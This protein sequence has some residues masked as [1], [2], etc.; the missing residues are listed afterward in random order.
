MPPRRR[1]RARRTRNRRTNKE[2]FLDALGQA[3]GNQQRLVSNAT[4]QEALNWESE[5]YNRIKQELLDEKKIIIGRGYGGS[6]GLAKAPGSGSL[7][8]FVSYCHADEALKNQLLSH[9]M[10]LKRMELIEVWHD[11]KIPAGGEWEQ[12]I[13]ANLEQA[14]IILMLIS[15][16]FINS[17]Y[18]YDI[19]L[20]RAI[21]KHEAGS[22]VVVPII[23]RSCM[24][25]HTSFSKLQALPKDGKP[26]CS[27]SDKDEAFTEIAGKIKEEAERL[28]ASR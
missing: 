2:L 1:R 25:K 14:D 26:V 15:I 19:E 23:L 5:R 21:E 6:V 13:S 9:L 16:D 28:L 12:A 3:S 8:V 20:E 17:Q 11:R 27:F 7:K 4:L 18:C 22:A 24:W 10:P